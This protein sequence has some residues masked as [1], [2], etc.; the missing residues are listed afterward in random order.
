[1]P[2]EPQ[3]TMPEQRRQMRFAVTQPARMIMGSGH[4]IIC[5][6]ADFCLGGL[7]LKF[8][9]PEKDGEWVATCAG[10]PNP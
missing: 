9:I 7:F 6:I 10:R 8:A 4:E 2:T 5:D 1:M 3:K